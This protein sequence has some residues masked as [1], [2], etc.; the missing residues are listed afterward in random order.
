MLGT[1]EPVNA[2]RLEFGL[3]GVLR[4]YNVSDLLFQHKTRPCHTSSS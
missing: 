1:S 2:H 4:I 3:N